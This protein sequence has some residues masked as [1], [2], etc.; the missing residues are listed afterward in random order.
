M[1]S[2]FHPFLLL[3][4]CLLLL[5]PHVVVVAQSSDGN[6]RVGATI[7]ASDNSET[8]LSPSNDFAL[9]FHQLENKNL[10][11][12]AIWYHKIPSRTIVWY[13]NGNN[14]VPR[15]SK[16]ELTADRGLVLTNLDDQLIWRSNFL[17]A[18]GAKKIP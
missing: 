5:L 1:A 4:A 14:P 11:L 17:S 12:L 9:G 8:W 3:S 10:F 2:V 18:E 13:A 7:V 15:R 16:V 6:I